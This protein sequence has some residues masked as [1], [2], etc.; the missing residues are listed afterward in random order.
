MFQVRPLRRF[1]SLR[2]LSTSKEIIKPSGNWANRS[3]IPWGQRNQLKIITE[4]AKYVPEG[5]DWHAWIIIPL[6]FVVGWWCANHVGVDH[7]PDYSWFKV[8]CFGFWAFCGSF[9]WMTH[10]GRHLGIAYTTM[11]CE[12]TLGFIGFFGQGSFWGSYK[13]MPNKGPFNGHYL[14]G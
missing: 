13:L 3:K 5:V 8:A 4:G 1:L 6:N 14:P 9:M 7:E 11:S 10:C 2:R 12:E